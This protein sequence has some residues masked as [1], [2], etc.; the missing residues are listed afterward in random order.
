[1]PQV[2]AFAVYLDLERARIALAGQRGLEAEHVVVTGIVEYGLER[3]G[4]V[5][6]SQ[7]RLTARHRCDLGQAL[8][9]DP[10]GL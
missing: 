2:D 8:L 5:A 10:L 3:D 9:V 1:M 4:G 7:G 6:G